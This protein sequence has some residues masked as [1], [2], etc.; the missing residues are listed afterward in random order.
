MATIENLTDKN[1]NI[2]YPITKMNAVFDNNNVDA[3]SHILNLQNQ[4]NANNMCPSD[5][6]A[7]F[8]TQPTQYVTLMTA[9]I[10]GV[11]YIRYALN[12]SGAIGVHLRTSS[13]QDL[14]YNTQNFD[15]SGFHIYTATFVMKA[16]QKLYCYENAL[17]YKW[18]SINFVKS[19][20]QS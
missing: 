3:G 5:T 13:G 9:P 11:A 16:G 4:I 6:T 14:A 7:T 19:E 18:G 12:G 15:T 8:T 10:N 2:I 20:G 1:D 17:T